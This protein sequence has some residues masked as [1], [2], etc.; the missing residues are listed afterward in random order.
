MTI[1]Q[2]LNIAVK[3]IKSAMPEALYKGSLVQQ[4]RAF[5]ASTSVNALVDSVITDVEVVFD[6]FTSEEVIGSTIMTTDVKLHI[7]A[8]EV[9]NIDFYQ[10]VRVRG[11]DYKIKR[12]LEVVVGSKAALFTI[13]AEL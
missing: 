9:F 12:K 8:N 6:N 5:N 11:A 4:T 2:I 1:D 13:V 10:I 7:I 3:S